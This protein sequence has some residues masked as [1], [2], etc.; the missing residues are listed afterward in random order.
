MGD[1]IFTVCQSTLPTVLLSELSQTF[2]L[3]NPLFLP[4]GNLYKYSICF[5]N[6]Q[7]S[8]IFSVSNASIAVQ[9]SQGFYIYILPKRVYWFI[10]SPHYCILECI[11]PLYL[12]KL[13]L[14]SLS[15]VHI[16]HKALSQSSLIPPK[17]NW[18]W[19]TFCITQQIIQFICRAP[20]FIFSQFMQNFLLLWHT[21][22][23]EHVY[24]EYKVKFQLLKWVVLSLLVITAMQNSSLQSCL[25]NNILLFYH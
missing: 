9:I 11:F 1:F 10:C 7:S 12:T 19:G 23:Q 4:T 20:F 5:A 22:N 17:V 18:I 2:S 3:K 13:V 6:W 8:Q 24:E 25:I 15:S 21:V 14:H 16:T